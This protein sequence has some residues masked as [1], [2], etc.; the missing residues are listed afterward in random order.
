MFRPQDA[1]ALHP[2]SAPSLQPLNPWD[3]FNIKHGDL[4]KVHESLV[5]VNQRGV[6]TAGNGDMVGRIMHWCEGSEKWP[7]GAPDPDAVGARVWVDLLLLEPKEK[8]LSAIVVCDRAQL[9]PFRGKNDATTRAVVAAHLAESKQAKRSAWN[10]YLLPRG[11]PNVRRPYWD[12]FLA[13]IDYADRL[14]CHIAA[15]R[16]KKQKAR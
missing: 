7:G 2:I 1:S 11:G 16:K 6:V 8:A 14:H 15:E 9:R 3:V 13:G 10:T 4:A 12:R 5:W